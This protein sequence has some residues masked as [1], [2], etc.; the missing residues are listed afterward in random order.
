MSKASYVAEFYS[1]NETSAVDVVKAPPGEWCCNEAS[2]EPTVMRY[3][4][5]RSLSIAHIIHTFSNTGD[6]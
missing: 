2:D 1:C 6:I 3:T 5:Q 4:L